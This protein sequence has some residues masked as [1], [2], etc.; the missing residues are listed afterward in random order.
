M[1]QFED[2]DVALNQLMVVY[3]YAVIHIYYMVAEWQLMM[4]HVCF[5]TFM[6]FQVCDLISY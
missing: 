6:L 1:L 3:W 5:V 2:A 4:V